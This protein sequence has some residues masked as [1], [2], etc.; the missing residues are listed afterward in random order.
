MTGLNRSM[1]RF[2]TQL[3]T[4]TSTSFQFKNI[5][6]AGVQLSTRVNSC[7]VFFLNFLSLPFPF[8]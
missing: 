4:N 8:P 1:I 6:H 5:K 7:Q 3:I 2:I